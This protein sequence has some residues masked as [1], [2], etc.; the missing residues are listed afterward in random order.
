MMAR[1]GKGVPSSSV[2]KLDLI[3]EGGGRSAAACCKNGERVLELSI[4]LGDGSASSSSDNGKNNSENCCFGDGGAKAVLIESGAAG[5]AFD[6]GEHRTVNCATVS[7][8][9]A[10]LQ[11][12]GSA[13]PNV[14]TNG[15]QTWSMSA[16]RNVH[17]CTRKKSFGS[18][19]GLSGMF[20]DTD[21][22][23]WRQKGRGLESHGFVLFKQSSGRCVLIG[24]TTCR[25]ATTSF[26][27][28]S[29]RAL[30][31]IDWG[32][33]GI[34]ESASENVLL[35][36]GN[37]PAA[38]IEEYADAVSASSDA[39]DD[40]ALALSSPLRDLGRPPIGWGSWYEFYEK[41]RARDIEEALAVLS[42]E[43]SGVDVVQI[44]D[45]FQSQTGDWLV[46]RNRFGEHIKEV[47]AKVKIAG[48]CPGIWVAPFIASASSRIFRKH[49][50]WFL[51]KAS[52]SGSYVRGHINPAWNRGW[53][54]FSKSIIHYVFDLS[55]KDVLQHL[56]ATFA[57]LREF[58]FAFFKIDF[59][60]A[61]M[62]EGIFQCGGTRVEAY[63]SGLKA[64]RRG[65]GP[66]SFLL[67]CGAPLMASAQSSVFDAFRITC[68]TAESWGYSF[69]LRA[70]VDDWC[71][72]C[73]RDALHGNMRR[74]FCASFWK[75]C[76][77]DCVVL[78]KRGNTMTEDEVKTQLTVV[79]MTGGLFLFTDNLKRLEPERRLLANGFLPPTPLRGA[80]LDLMSGD[81]A[82]SRFRLGK[83][84]QHQVDAIINFAN[85]AVSMSVERPGFEFWSE[86]Y[87]SKGTK[88]IP[89]HGC[90]A[91]QFAPPS[92]KVVIGCTLHL[93]CLAD[94]RVRVV[95]EIRR[96]GEAL[97]R[98][99]GSCSFARQSGVLI[100]AAAAGCSNIK[101]VAQSARGCAVEEVAIEGGR[102]PFSLEK[103]SDTFSFAFTVMNTFEK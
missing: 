18:K 89:K 46:V 43:N 76:D 12:D 92:A 33:A 70:L 66:K 78:R 93:C 19:L 39:I 58:G 65:I 84:G 68:D 7:F 35:L 51:K 81:F 42:T 67:G 56:T 27:I 83:E 28:T 57:K 20:L 100:V 14:F 77:P 24:A 1:D 62:R 38:L 17:R 34:S 9:L 63:I 49:P 97:V 6:E 82:P 16:P 37:D 48:Y 103:S 75:F 32:T 61:G 13:A 80:P 50:E 10:D 30:M 53:T 22:P 74:W 95:E 2:Q 64:I 91:V 55:R 8:S 23:T 59:L 101:L 36:C 4:C 25:R 102:I 96:T 40:P 3:V 45:G 21:A 85:K 87:I 15:Y 29:E 86:R 41:V 99:T 90:L 79:G 72:P 31:F 88:K 26:W 52:G 54:P 94:G 60:A 71:V 5:V 11:N 73:C 47:A 69:L 44:D 98:V